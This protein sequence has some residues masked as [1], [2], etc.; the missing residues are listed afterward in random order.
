MSEVGRTFSKNSF[1]KLA[2]D[3]PSALASASTK[4]PTPRDWVGPA[5]RC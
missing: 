5:G 2:N 3:L 1:S 4:S